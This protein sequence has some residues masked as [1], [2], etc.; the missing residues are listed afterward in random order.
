MSVLMRQTSKTIEWGTPQDLF[1]QLNEEFGPFT[2][3]L[4]ASAKNAKCRVYYTKEDDGLEQSWICSAAWL[5]PPYGRDLAL[6]VRRAALD[7]AAAVIVA[8]L[9]AR[10]D[11]KWFHEYVLPKADVIRFLPGRVYFENPNH[12]RDRAPFPSMVVVWRKK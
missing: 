11:T 5:N 10:T 8:L 12:E 6:W 9:P 4:C 7:R 2:I 3:D 1:D